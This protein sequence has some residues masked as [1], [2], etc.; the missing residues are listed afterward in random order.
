MTTNFEAPWAFV[1]DTT[2]YAGNFE[3]ELCAYI[4]GCVGE[5]GVGEEMAALHDEQVGDAMTESLEWENGDDGCD[6]PCSIFDSKNGYR[7]VII[8]FRKKPTKAEVERMMKRA[9]EYA[10]LPNRFT[11]SQPNIKKILGFRI[12]KNEVV[13]TLKTVEHISL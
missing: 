1:I 9:Q 3:R 6:R 13:R 10:A 7:S 11:P 8:F 4:T 12:L 2:D 5:C